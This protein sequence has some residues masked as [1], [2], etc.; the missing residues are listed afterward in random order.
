MKRRRFQTFHRCAPFKSFK[1]FEELKA[2]KKGFDDSGM[3]EVDA[4]QRQYSQVLQ[5]RPAGE[6]FFGKQF[7]RLRFEC[8]VIEIC[9][10]GSAAENSN[11]F[12]D[13]RRLAFKNLE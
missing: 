10:L 3:L 12:A 13:F 1:S 11:N 4:R 6:R 8:Y 5:S 7:H 2:K 9:F